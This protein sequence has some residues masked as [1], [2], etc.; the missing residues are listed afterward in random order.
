[1]AHD[2]TDRAA[3]QAELRRKFFPETAIGNFSRIDHVVEFYTRVNALLAPD[4][5]V[6]DFGAGRGQ[7]YVNPTSPVRMQL[8]DMRSRVQKVIG[9]DVDP[10]V[11]S[12]PSLDEAYVIRP[13]EPLPLADR[14]VDIIVSD[15]TFEHIADPEAVSAELDRVLRPDGWICA[16]TPNKHGYIGLGARVVPNRWHVSWLRRLQPRRREE[17][18][19][20]VVYRLNTAR[21]IARFFPAQHYESIIY[22]MPAEPAYAGTSLVLWSAFNVLSRVQPASLNPMLS[23]FLHKRP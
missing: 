10:V 1:M 8:R 13:G 12:N 18:V 20:P 5:V 7:W 4:K 6:L 11:K 3:R 21:D 14:S 22:T 9:L 15:Y 23:I 16:R 17:D 19:F 2:T